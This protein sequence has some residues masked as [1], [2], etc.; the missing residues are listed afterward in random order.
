MEVVPKQLLGHGNKLGPGGFQILCGPSI[1]KQAMPL[2]WDL[3]SIQ[4][5]ALG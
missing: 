1:N 3:G 4:V 5:T 2:D